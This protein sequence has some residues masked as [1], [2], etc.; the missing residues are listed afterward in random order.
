MDG[1]G[2]GGGGG[3]F[4]GLGDVFWV[5]ADGLFGRFGYGFSFGLGFGCV[6]WSKKGDVE[7]KVHG[8]YFFG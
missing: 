5:W 2:G 3:A 1:L 8:C 6:R 4:F 7:E